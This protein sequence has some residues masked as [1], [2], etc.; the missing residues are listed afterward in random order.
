MEK[1]REP[2]WMGS[3]LEFAWASNA[4]NIFR[5]TSSHAAKNWSFVVLGIGATS[6]A[7]TP[8]GRLSK[9]EG[10]LAQILPRFLDNVFGVQARS[11]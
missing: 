10:F 3:R 5:P 1:P 11:T 9:S 4:V 7:A 2:Q 6:G 8:T